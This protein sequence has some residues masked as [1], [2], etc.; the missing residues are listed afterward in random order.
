MLQN[1]HDRAQ[2][3]ITQTTQKTVQLEKLKKQNDQKVIRELIRKQE[4]EQNDKITGNG[5]P[6]AIIRKQ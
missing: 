1:E 6:Y 4:I 5:V 2:K 3:K